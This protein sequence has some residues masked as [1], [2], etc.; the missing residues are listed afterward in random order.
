[1]AQNHASSKNKCETVN[2]Y[3]VHDHKILL[4]EGSLALLKVK[5]FLIFTRQHFHTH[6]YTGGGGSHLLN[7]HFTHC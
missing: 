1:M 7:C 6:S 3:L 5:V 4:L 2:I